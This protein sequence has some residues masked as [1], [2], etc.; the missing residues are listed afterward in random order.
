MRL[1]LLIIGVLSLPGLAK[2][3]LPS[4]RLDRLSVLGVNQGGEV[5]LEVSGSD[6]EGLTGLV[7]DHPGLLATAIEGKERWFKLKATSDIPPGTFD[8][9]TL[10]RFGV[11]SSRLFAVSRGLKDVA[12][13]GQNRSIAEA[14]IIAINSAING[15]I[16]GNSEDMYK[17][18]GVKGQRL[19]I[20]CQAQ[21]LDSELD[22]QLSV[23]DSL[24]RTIAGNG[25]SYG[26]DPF[27][28]V[29]LP[30]DG[31]YRIVV[32]DLSYRGGSPYRL[33]VSN[34]PHVELVYPAAVQAE[35]TASLTAFGTNLGAGSKPSI[36]TVQDQTLDEFSFTTAIGTE[37]LSVGA[38]RFQS[39][40][41]HHSVLP[42]AATATLLGR[43]VVEAS[44]DNT[45]NG[46]PLLITDHPVS[47]EAEPND[48]REKAQPITLPAV[49]A[50][51]F[52][53]PRDAD[54][55]EFTADA[56]GEYYFDVYCERIAGR[57]DPYLVVFD[58]QE[59]RVGELDDYGHR[60]NAFDGHLRDPSAQG[61]R[62]AK[63]KTYRILVQDRYQRGGGRTQYVLEARK[64]HPD[65]FAAVI[66]GTN[67]APSGLNLWKGTASFLDVVI[68]QWEGY[69]GPVVVTAEG[70]PPGMHAEP[71]QITSNNRGTFVVWTDEDAPDWNGS[72]RLTIE[73]EL[74]G[75]KFRREVRP[76]TRVTN[77]LSSSRPTRE[78]AAS[79]REQGPYSVTCEPR[80]LSIESGKD[81]Q[82]KVTVKRLWS[83]FTDKV[84]L[85]PLN[86]PGQ[87]QLGNFDIAGDQTEAT[88]TIKVQAGTQPGKYSLTL[89]GQGQ[90]P[91][92]KDPQSQDRP[93]TLV[94]I[95]CRP[96][97]ITI[98]APPK[99]NP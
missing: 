31:E 53:V 28:D 32:N 98:S 4:P 34:L 18:I 89:L 6:L 76:Y 60:L 38:Y 25:D 33:V 14:Q 13:N 73:G 95:P 63:D 15:T 50:G 12:D 87:I 16:D 47:L 21:R 57:A 9:R 69:N 68:H 20:D 1:G 49:V 62:L 96:F 61:V 37:E 77:S 72:L 86:W 92:H 3:E 8:V 40:P 70:L 7:F 90:V 54:W 71:L 74:N 27:V 46:Q 85:Q 48:H 59:N 17:L 58:D 19:W 10:G 67:P 41:T 30:E 78:L 79:I 99:P 55:F 94:S 23:I 97:T 11:S 83:G 39:H 45:F 5:E 81:A 80:E 35:T 22:G 82:I 51:R 2:A 43:Q 65:L 36:W 44:F 64:P 91:F 93:N 24:G 42:T 84:S 75:E 66:H 26:V 29:T 56:D 88:V 52:D